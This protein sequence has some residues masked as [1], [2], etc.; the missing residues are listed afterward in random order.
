M[1]QIL[2]RINWT[3][4]ALLLLFLSM[5]AVIISQSINM[6]LNGIRLG[7]TLPISILPAF[8]YLVTLGLPTG[9]FIT[10]LGPIL[11][12]PEAHNETSALPAQEENTN[13]IEQGII[14][15]AE[16]SYTTQK[17]LKSPLL[18]SHK[19]EAKH[20]FFLKKNSLSDNTFKGNDKSEAP[21]P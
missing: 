13:Q 20:A 17:T 6:I 16:L 10:Q 12:E 14:L 3:N 21:S 18:A 4:M 2:N 7:Q 1:R 15:N 11:R 8:A 19:N 9:V 5:L